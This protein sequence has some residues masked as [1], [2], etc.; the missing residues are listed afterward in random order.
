[1]AERSMFVYERCSG[2]F[3]KHIKLT[4][5]GEIVEKAGFAL[6]VLEDLLMADALV[7]EGADHAGRVL[8]G[9]VNVG[10]EFKSVE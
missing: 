6:Q 9:I 8:V 5:T 4:L 3:K 2:V 10:L 7:V 1:M